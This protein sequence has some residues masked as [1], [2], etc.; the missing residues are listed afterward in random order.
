MKKTLLIFTS[1]LLVYSCN[2][3]IQNNLEKTNIIQKKSSKTLNVGKTPH[4]IYYAAGFVYN[5]NIGDNTISIIDTKTD[6][7]VETLKIENGTP[8]YI[9]SFHDEK[10]IIVS[11][12]KKGELIII[13]P[14]KDNNIIQTI[15]VGNV[16]DEIIVTDDDKKV[17]ISLAQDD[18]IVELI[19]GENRGDSPS[20]REIKVG[21]MLSKSESRSISLFNNLL[22]VSNTADNDVSLINIET[23]SERRLRDGNNPAIN[24]IATINGKENCVIVGNSSSNTI[25]IFDINSDNKTTLSDIGLYPAEIIL[26][27]NKNRAFITMTGSNE[28]SVIDYQKKTLINKIKVGKRP[29]HIYGVN[30]NGYAKN[31]SEIEELWVSNDGDNSVS[32][33]DPI[34]MKVKYNVSVGKGHHKIAFSKNKAYISNITDNTISIIE[35]NN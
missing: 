32:V 7:I 28:V 19:F 9:K 16:P 15:S 14:L 27:T 33:I 24:K 26:Y 1:F 31:N 34:E 10:N 20:K 12:T 25:S 21:N 5:S 29:L 35:R 30:K 23:N 4:G 13:D 8:G 3:N 18:K 17:Y 6:N 2:N 11:D 22:S